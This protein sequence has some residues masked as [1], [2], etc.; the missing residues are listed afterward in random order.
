MEAKEARAIMGRSIAMEYIERA[1]LRGEISV[2]I[3]KHYVDRGYWESKGY[4]VT[5]GEHQLADNCTVSWERNW[6]D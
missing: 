2:N 3:P 1:A 6:R 5:G 4:R